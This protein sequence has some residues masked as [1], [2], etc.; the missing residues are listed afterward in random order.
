M[1][2]L[3]KLR[4]RLRAG[5]LAKSSACIALEK[6]AARERTAALVHPGTGSLLAYDQYNGEAPGLVHIVN[7]VDSAAVN[8]PY[9][10]CI[11]P[12]HHRTHYT[13]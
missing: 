6:M 9:Q 3:A 2:L 11:L 12:A 5:G 10:D 4:E 7:L 8:L 13:K 1:R